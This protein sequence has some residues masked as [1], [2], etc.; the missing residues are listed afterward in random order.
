MDLLLH[1]SLA[2]GEA[3]AL[4]ANLAL[5]LAGTVDATADGDLVFTF[6]P[7]A[8]PPPSTEPVSTELLRRDGPPVTAWPSNI[9]GLPFHQWVAASV[10]A[11]CSF[12]W[13]L[14]FQTNQASEMERFDGGTAWT[15]AALHLANAGACALTALCAFALRTAAASG[16]LR[17]CRRIACASAVDALAG[18]RAFI[19]A[20]IV[21]RQLVDAVHAV[22]PAFPAADIRTAVGGAFADVGARVSGE[23]VDL[24]DVQ[25]RVH[26]V[27]QQARPAE[28]G[29]ER[30]VYDTA[31]PVSG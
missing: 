20:S 29:A 10:M 13:M 31:G 1:E 9:P 6:P 15:F 4:G 8:L 23:R 7:T 22:W 24:E 27:E 19:N 2:P 5:S 18:G 11:A 12:W 21:E 14:L 28:G 26:G 25:R 17:D 3:E 30:L 16:V